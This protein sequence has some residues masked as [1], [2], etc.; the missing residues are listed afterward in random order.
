MAVIRV[1]SHDLEIRPISPDEIEAV[2]NV[3]KQCEDFLALGPVATASIEMVQQDIAHSKREGG[4]FCGIYN[5]SGEMIGVLDYVPRNYEGNPSHASLELLMIVEPYRN[6]G[7]GK[8]VV[9]A[10]K[11]EI[12]KDAAVRTIL[13]GVQVNNPQAVR[14]WQRLGYRIVSGPRLMP[15]QTTAYALQKDLE[16]PKFAGF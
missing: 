13:S 8:A 11:D 2:L 3:Y 9:E 15:D 1:S 10:F 16:G 12:R 6:R 7:I 14:F 5:A 4:I